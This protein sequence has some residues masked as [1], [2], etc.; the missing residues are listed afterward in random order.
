[1]PNEDVAEFLDSQRWFQN[2]SRERQGR[3]V[4][5]LSAALNVMPRERRTT[6]LNESGEFTEAFAEE[7]RR[8]MLEN[9]RGISVP[10]RPPRGG[11]PAG[12]AAPSGGN[13]P[14]ESAPP[15]LRLHRRTVTL[16]KL[17][18]IAP[19]ALIL[20]AAV[21][22]EHKG[23]INGTQSRFFHSSLTGAFF[24]TDAGFAVTLFGGAP[25]AILGG[26]A[27]SFA[28]DRTGLPWLRRGSL[29]NKYVSIGGGLAGF[30]ASL[31]IASR[32]APYRNFHAATAAG[33]QHLYHT[34]VSKIGEAGAVIEEG[35]AGAL[36]SFTTGARLYGREL[37]SVA[38]GYATAVQTG[39]QFFLNTASR[40]T[41]PIF[42]IG[43]PQNYLGQNNQI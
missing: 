25:G 34:V 5:I 10:P 30:G 38:S 18:G 26:S 35:L 27:A 36:R 32:F 29:G 42:L 4:F 11:G 40:L 7:A 24:A 37:V 22:A 33:T 16:E 21:T 1:M 31:K 2:L 13:G 28:A 39:A 41:T 6:F 20:G 19:L 23:W 9:P 43:D 3:G 12:G 17:G 14:G 8:F 15:N